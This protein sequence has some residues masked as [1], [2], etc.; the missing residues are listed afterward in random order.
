[1]KHRMILVVLAVAAVAGIPIGQAPPRA[2]PARPDPKEIPVP[3]IATSMKKMPGVN[4]LPN[5]PEMPDVLTMNNGK[6][7]ATAA[8]WKRRREEMKQILEYYAVGQAPPAAGK[9]EGP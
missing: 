2:I 6:K 4:E 1:M 3:P 7:V 5:R 9:C 8:Q